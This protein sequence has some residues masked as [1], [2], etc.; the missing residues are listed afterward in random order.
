M[1]RKTDSFNI[2]DISLQKGNRNISFNVN[3]KNLNYNKII[4]KYILNLPDKHKSHFNSL[5]FNNEY[6]VDEKITRYDESDAYEWHIDYIVETSGVRCL[7]TITY[8]NDNYGG[9]ETQFIGKTIQPKKGSTL[10]FPSCWIFPHQ[11]NLVTSGSKLIYVCH[12]W[13]ST[14]KNNKINFYLPSM[15]S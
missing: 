12:F 11:G 14:K 8:L 6:F 1:E 7:S 4:Q 13:I 9:G 5:F 3:L 15:Y 2:K 10:I